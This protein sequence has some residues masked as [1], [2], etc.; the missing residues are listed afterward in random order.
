MGKERALPRLLLIYSKIFLEQGEG[1]SRGGLFVQVENV[2]AVGN[3]GRVWQPVG[4]LQMDIWS[5]AC[6]GESSKLELAENNA[7][8][9]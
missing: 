5:M 3:G 7:L 4:V 6:G 8:G 2:E 9:V 1:W